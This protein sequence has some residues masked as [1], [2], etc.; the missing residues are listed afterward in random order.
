MFTILTPQLTRLPTYLVGAGAQTPEGYTHR[1]QG[2]KMHQIAIVTKGNGKMMIHDEDISLSQGDV[3]CLSKNQAHR[4]FATEPPMHS[5]WILFDGTASDT[6]MELLTDGTGCLYLSSVPG[7][8]S[9]I[10]SIVKHAEQNGQNQQLSPMIYEL[11]MELLRQKEQTGSDNTKRLEPAIRYMEEHLQKPLSLEEI[12]S[13]L[14]LSKFQFCKLFRET[15]LITPFTYLTQLRLQNAKELL[16]Q[17][18]NISVKEAAL[19]SGFR[20][21]SYFG[22]VFRRHERMTPKEFQIQYWKN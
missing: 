22:A 2:M 20:D 15:Y 18:P 17:N 11:L 13:V 1:P 9:R 7:I 19:S 12:A 5:L 6:L 21:V 8:Q 3:F 10:Q 14:A 16:S 4:Y